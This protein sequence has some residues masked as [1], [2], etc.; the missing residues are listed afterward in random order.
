[1]NFAPGWFPAISLK[2]YVTSLS[3]VGQASNTNSAN[4]TLP[5][6]QA[7]DI[8]V[9]FH[10]AGSGSL[11]A[12]HTPTGFANLINQNNGT[13][14]RWMV[15]WKIAVASDSGATIT[16]MNGDYDYKIVLVVRPNL[17][18]TSANVLSLAAVNESADPSAQ[19]VTSSNSP[20]PLIVFGFY[21]GSSASVT[22][23][24]S[25]A[26][27]NT[28]GIDTTIYLAY[29]IYNSVAADVTVDMTDR[30]Y[31]FLASFYI[32]VT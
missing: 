12:T 30:G 5:T 15:D 22:P 2:E 25:P 26:A 13:S 6:L 32:A 14:W 3:Y 9:L 21:F 11:P 1:M 27:D 28:I 10:W 20:A 19:V 8:I 23:S 31:N 29:K 17:P 16:G 24:F 7:G 4:I 18:L